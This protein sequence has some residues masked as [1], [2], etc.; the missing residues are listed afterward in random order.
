MCIIGKKVLG[1]SIQYMDMFSDYSVIQTCC[2]ID[3]QMYK[4]SSDSQ[5]SVLAEAYVWLVTFSSTFMQSKH[6]EMSFMNI[7]RNHA[8]DLYRLYRMRC[9]SH[10][11]FMN[12]KP[13]RKPNANQTVG[14]TC[15]FHRLDLLLLHHRWLYFTYPIAF[16]I[17]VIYLPYIPR[18]MHYLQYSSVNHVKQYPII[19]F[20]YQ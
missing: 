14:H 15:N 16:R 4:W 13:E 9:D 5:Q 10:Q 17:F 11:A 8:R 2:D 7:V 6:E 19:P 12:L 20:L 3:Q 18:I 1:K